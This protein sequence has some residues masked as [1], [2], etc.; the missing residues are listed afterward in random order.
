[1][2]E[3][4]KKLEQISRGNDQPIGFGQRTKVKSAPMMLV[5]K[6]EHIEPSLVGK[7]ISS[8]CD[9][10]LFDSKNTLEQ[11]AKITNISGLIG[12]TPWG[13]RLL[14][15]NPE[16][17][18][19]FREEGCDYLVINSELPAQLLQEEGI[20]RLLE[21]ESSLGNDLAET[22]GV[23]QVD[24]LL[25]IDKTKLDKVSI[26]Q[27]MNYGRLLALADKPVLMTLPESSADLELLFETG[28]SGVLVEMDLQDTEDKLAKIKERINNL[29]SSK[30]VKSEFARTPL[31]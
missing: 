4:I 9:A 5:V 23:I 11:L 25:I 27:L 30:K 12:K 19:R 28:V 3:F 17:V 29:P 20:G 26:Q 14:T 6:L 8:G 13:V 21:V 15:D 10:I 22:I 7:A 16:D 2:S 31:Q 1:M 24:A 18:E